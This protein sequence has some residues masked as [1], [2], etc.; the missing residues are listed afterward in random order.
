MSV[1][2]AT[3]LILSVLLVVFVAQN[4]A[5]VEIRFLFW[6]FEASRAVLLFLCLLAGAILGWLLSHF[7]HK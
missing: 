3:L 7:F 4:Y 6:S 1:K 5:V 2:I